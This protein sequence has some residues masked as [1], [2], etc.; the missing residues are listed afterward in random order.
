LGHFPYF[1]FRGEDDRRA[2]REDFAR[3]RRLFQ[4]HFN[5]DI[6]GQPAASA[7][8]KHFEG[9]GCCEGCITSPTAYARPRPDRSALAAARLSDAT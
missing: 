6:G 7:C 1:G 8:R 5:I 4:E 9:S 2:W 3:T